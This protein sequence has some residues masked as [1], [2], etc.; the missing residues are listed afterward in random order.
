MATVLLFLTYLAI[1][2]LIG[3]LTSI[4]SQKFKIPNILLLLFI[5]IGIGRVTYKGAPIIF[6][7]ELFITGI[8]IMALVMIVFDSASRFKLKN[9]DYFSLHVLWLSLVFIV[10]NLVLLT[11]FIILIFD[12]KSIF[13][14][15]MFSALMSGTDPAAVLS[16]LKNSKHKVFEF[17]KLESL[18]NT[19]LVVLLPFLILDLKT[20]L[21]GQIFITTLI[22]QFVPLLQQ[23]IVGVGTG[24]L[25]GLI[26]FKFM[27]KRYS[28]VLSPLAVIT[29]ALLTYTIAENLQG[30]GVLAVTTMGILFGNVYVK[31]KFQLQEFSSIFST[32]LEILVFVLI[33]LIVAI[34][35][36]LIFFIKSLIL[37]SLYLIIRFIAILFSLRGMN[38]SLLEKVFMS[39]NVQKGIAVAV[40][41]FS[42]ATLNIVGIGVILNLVL[43]FMLYSIILSSIVLRFT[44][45]FLKS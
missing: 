4:V 10:F 29:A 7:P 12:I 40:V 39:L 6:F 31:Q 22:E 18:L 34:P 35:F 43:T 2:L 42:L 3:L 28:I 25:I 30:N 16:M 20:A 32:S 41:I 38:F 19:P 15:F 26:M 27:R 24:V 37:F 11:A 9:L 21:K 14:A 17:L 36:S 45:F 8:S 5:G 33:G 23:F 44:N 13:L 1:I